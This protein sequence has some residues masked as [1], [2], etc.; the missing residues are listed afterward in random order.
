MQTLGSVQDLRAYRRWFWPSFAVSFLFMGLLLPL[1]ITF[2]G[3]A[4]AFGGG[5]GMS[6][7]WLLSAY[8]VVIGLAWLATRTDPE[9][10]GPQGTLCGASWGLAL[11]A[12]FVVV[13]V[14]ASS[15]RRRVAAGGTEGSTASPTGTASQNR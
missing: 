5:A 9:R 15:L 7:L 14:V 2:W 10:P 8:P 12:L 3:L 1:V 13:M 11:L 4:W 6:P